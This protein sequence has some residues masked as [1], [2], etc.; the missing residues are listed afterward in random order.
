VPDV[1]RV[2]R[3]FSYYGSKH[4]IA[5]RYPAP[6]PGDT[7]VE[8][9]AGSASYACLYYR[10]AVKLFDVNPRVVGVWD[11]LI[12]STP[13]DILR[14]PLFSDGYEDVRQMPVCQ[15]ARWLI[16]W[17]VNN[18]TSEPCNE[19]SKWMRSGLRPTCQWGEVTRQRV[20][21]GAARIKHW[22]IEQRSFATLSELDGRLDITWFID[23]PYQGSAGR[24]YTF[25]RLDYGL[26]SLWCRSRRGQVIVCEN[27]GEA[28]WLPFMPL[29]RQRSAVNDGRRKRGKVEGIWHRRSA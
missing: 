20:A 12:R 17:W 11:F 18:C 15:E 26:L 13:E 23:P 16:G 3:L 9:F 22:T 4:R 7:I 8:P 10:H 6:R 19:A 5:G 14:L 2:P 24:H 25:D 1:D 27:Y 21:D 28:D 29:V